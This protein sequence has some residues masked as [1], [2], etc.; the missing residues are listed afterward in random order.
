M[1]QPSHDVVYLDYALRGRSGEIRAGR[2]RARGTGSDGEFRALR[3]FWQFPD[4]RHIDV[5]RSV[6]DPFGDVLVRQTHAR[7]SATIIIMADLSR[8]MQ[9]TRGAGSMRMV[10]RL[11][12]AAARSALKAGDSFG[13]LGF[14]EGLHDEFCLAPSR[15]WGP[16]AE[17]LERLEVL[18]PAGRSAAGI[19]DLVSKLPDRR[20]LIVLVSDFLMPVQLL[21]QALEMFAGHDVAP[22][23][24]HNRREQDLP[25]SGIVR[26][27]DSETGRRRLLLMRPSLR[28]RWHEA[29]GKWRMS[30]DSCFLRHCRPGFHVEAELDLA[31]LGEHLLAG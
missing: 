4:T 30:L 7:C 9:T 5:R 28:R 22:V 11:A 13:F 23:V 19:L 24:L 6:A 31:Q 15:S 12:S 3:P 29:R 14:S 27:Q 1:N 8:S 20:S 25:L 2:H 21:E 10:A 26:L 18:Q 16:V 17:L